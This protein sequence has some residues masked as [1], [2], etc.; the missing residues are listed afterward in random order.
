MKPEHFSVLVDES[1]AAL[2]E[3]S[4]G[5]GRREGGVYVD[6]TFGRGGHTRRILA[7]VPQNSKLLVFDKD[8]EAIEVAHEMAKSDERLSIHRGSFAQMDDVVRS[9]GWDGV[10][11]ILLDLGVSSPQLDNAERGFSFLR[12]GPL[13]MRMDPDRGESAADWI[14]RESEQGIAKVLWEY[15]EERYSR[16][17]ARAIVEE[18][19]IEP[20]TRTARF[21]EIVKRAHPRWEKDRHPAT[22]T[23]QGVRIHVNR[24]LEDLE[25]ALEA[26]VK[27]L[28]P[29]GRL[30]VISFHS[31][32][33]RIVKQFFRRAQKG[34]VLP[35]EVAI[36]NDMWK[37]SLKSIGKAVRAGAE[38]LDLNVRSRSATMRVA[39]KP[40]HTKVD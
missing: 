3:S 2:L 28:R 16:R 27:I 14:N 36:T 20:I 10:D 23:F 11:G 7:S 21:A 22:K 29:G 35:K 26:A 13:D 32:E 40:R 18:R 6:G 15:G 19:E 38:E 8:P 5:D 17:I 12:D 37:P 4:R 25:R 24:E 34:P 33:D 30:V 31:L 39:E 9:L 1:V